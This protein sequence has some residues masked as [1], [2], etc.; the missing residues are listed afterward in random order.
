MNRT[1]SSMLGIIPIL[2]VFMVYTSFETASARR[3]HSRASGHRSVNR[4]VNTHGKR[5][6]NINTHRHVDVD[7]HHH[8][9]GG[10]GI[11]MFTGL[12]IGTAIATP[13]P[14]YTTVVVSGTNY[15][16]ADGVYYQTAPSSGYVV[17]GA[18]IGATV[19][20]VPPGA[21]QVSLGAT[22]YYYLN[23]AYYVQ[24]GTAF[25]VVPTPIGITVPTLPA[26]AASTTTNGQTYFKFQSIYYQPVIAS[27]V[28]AYM[29]VKM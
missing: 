27:G 7:V 14:T 22:T 12:A 1:F 15:L 26:G 23:G 18:P 8:S 9:R 3:I 24:Q 17:V 11:G 6:V 5:N 20:A 10:F 4:N 29:T 13:P 21:V 25:Q 2:V 28:T 16:Y 19:A